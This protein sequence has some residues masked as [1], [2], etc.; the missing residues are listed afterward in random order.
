VSPTSPPAP[1]LEEVIVTGE[2][3][4]PGLWHVSRGTAQLWILGSVSP[5]PKDMTWR[6]KQLESILDATD[7]VLVAKPV[8]MGLARVVWLML[9]ER[10][11]FSNGGGRKLR[12]VMPPNLYARFAAQRAKFTDDPHKWEKYRP[13]IASLFLQEAALRQ[14]GL[15]TRLDIAD[16]VRGLARKH[17]VRIDEVKIA[18]IHDV[19]DALKTLPAATEYA[20]VAA[21]LA[22]VET[23]LPRLIERAQAWATGNVERMQRLPEPPEV[24]ACRA[25]VMTNAGSADLLALVRRTWLE[26][27]ERHLQNGGV[28]L[29]VVSMDMLLPPG[30]FLDE[31]RSA[32]Y[33]VDAP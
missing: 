6:S 19:L 33:A 12:D 18:G 27:M 2:R 26:N 15:S 22:T 7:R 16:E 8:E 24:G 23:G 9:T 30:G 28:T 32:G 3:A 31:L 11:L 17:H 21:G 25:A 5:L 14:V 10:E 29:A 1:A 13:A 4:G 20:C